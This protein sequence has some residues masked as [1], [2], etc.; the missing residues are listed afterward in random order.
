MLFFFVRVEATLIGE[1]PTNNQASDRHGNTINTIDRR[2]INQPLAC[3]Q[4]KMRVAD[5]RR[6]ICRR[7]HRLFQRDKQQQAFGFAFY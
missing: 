3:E 1:W 2:S 5:R 7:R 4:N 6:P